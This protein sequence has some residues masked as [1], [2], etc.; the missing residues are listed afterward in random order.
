MASSVDR[1][2]LD[3]AVRIAASSRVSIADA[4]LDVVVELVCVVLSVSRVIL[5]SGFS[6]NGSE[7]I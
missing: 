3:F 2:R 4:L 5:I 7:I 6:T 1:K